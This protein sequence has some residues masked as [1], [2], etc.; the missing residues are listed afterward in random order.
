MNNK[1]KL[2]TL[3]AMATFVFAA[4]ANVENPVP[5]IVEIEKP[6]EKAHIF[7]SDVVEIEYASGVVTTI[8]YEFSTFKEGSESYMSSDGNCYKTTRNLVDLKRN[9][10][11]GYVFFTKES[12][13]RTVMIECPSNLKL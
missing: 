4:N 10:V 2:L 7:D 6:I 9:E 1:F 11:R 13:N 8:E 12:K 3:S 5:D